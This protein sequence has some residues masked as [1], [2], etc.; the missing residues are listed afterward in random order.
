MMHFLGNNPVSSLKTR[1]VLSINLTEKAWA[2]PTK[3]P[4]N[5]ADHNKEQYNII[6]K[7]RGSF[8]LAVA[9]PA[10]SREIQFR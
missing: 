5:Y 9:Y 10:S 7:V 1:V 3:I 8:R 6:V 4:L 2:I